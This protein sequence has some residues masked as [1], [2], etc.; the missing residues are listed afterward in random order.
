MACWALQSAEMPLLLRA[1]T[2]TTTTIRCVVPPCQVEKTR[3][4]NEKA[5]AK[6]S[7][8]EVQA[9]ALTGVANGAAKASERQLAALQKAKTSAKGVSSAGE[10]ARLAFRWEIMKGSA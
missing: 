5:K 8:V 6:A 3:E 2:M 1:L 7:A 9:R 10:K 4:L